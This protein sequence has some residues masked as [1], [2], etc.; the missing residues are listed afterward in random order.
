MFRI[1][2]A[3]VSKLVIEAERKPEKLRELKAREKNKADT[4]KAVEKVTSTFIE[5]N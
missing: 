2:P 1:S 3:L 4:V 5:N